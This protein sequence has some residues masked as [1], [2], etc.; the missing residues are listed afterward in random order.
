MI[1]VSLCHAYLCLDVITLYH[2]IAAS[3]VVFKMY[4][5]II[6]LH[7]NMARYLHNNNPNPLQL[8]HKKSWNTHFCIWVFKVDYT[9]GQVTKVLQ[10]SLSILGHTRI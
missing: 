3:L 9:F 4:V 5:F 6:A 2:G 8:F 1:Y 10:Q 7:N